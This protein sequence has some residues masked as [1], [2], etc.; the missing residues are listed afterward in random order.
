LVYNLKDMGIRFGST[1]IRNVVMEPSNIA[2]TLRPRPWIRNPRWLDMPTI[3][4]NESRF[5]AL[6]GISSEFKNQFVF[7]VNTTSGDYTVDWGDG[8]TDTYA[9]NAVAE[10]TY[11]YS[12]LN[13]NTE[14]THTKDGRT[15]RQALISVTPQAG[16][17]FDR[18]DLIEDPPNNSHPYSNPRM[19]L[20]MVFGS[21]NITH[22]SSISSIAGNYCKDLEHI[23]IVSFSD[24]LTSFHTTFGYMPCLKSI[25][26]DR[27]TSNI[28][29]W[30]NAFYECYSIEQIP[31]LDFSGATTFQNTF[32]RCMKLVEA[33]S[34]LSNA[35]PTRVDTMFYDCVLLRKIPM[36]DT[37]NCTNFK[38]MFMYCRNLDFA[39]PL[40]TSNGTDFYRMFFGCRSLKEI[41]KNLDTSSTNQTD[42]N[43]NYQM[44]YDCN[45]IQTIPKLTNLAGSLQSMFQQCFNLKR[46]PAIDFSKA[47]NT[48][49]MFYNCNSLQSL[50]A[51]NITGS[52]TTFGMFGYCYSLKSIDSLATN[53]STDFNGMFESCFNLTKLPDDFT[54]IS[55]SNPD[56]FERYLGNTYCL[57]EITEG[58][59]SGFGNTGVTDYDE[60][61]E[62]TFFRKL[63]NSFTGINNNASNITKMTQLFNQARGV[64]HV[65]TIDASNVSVSMPNVFAN[66]YCLESGAILSGVTQN[67]SYL[68]TNLDRE[69]MV[70]IFSGLGNASQTIN[71]NQTP[72]EG[73]LTDED[74]AIATNKGWTI[75]T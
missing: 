13:A 71:I 49:Y 59:C 48:Q 52:T 27:S 46:I 18:V 50:P 32:Y 45:Q 40:D 65:P 61:F 34:S 73:N 60:T 63:P 11:N 41:P 62:S 16:Q 29:N 31:E 17:G 64:K 58:A 25:E 28:T 26:I 66:A 37:S 68:S 55:A 21:P 75:A 51:L 30:T 36:M 33:P 72:A 57:Y 42:S 38:N 54:T 44:F 19:Y 14:F 9:D 67:I 4:S 6:V 1:P 10:H 43:P 56:A 35:S 47:T 23:R 2:R 69:A 20:D 53:S 24:S 5:T 70:A 3:A 22:L 7:K 8:N 12:D 39:P 15:Y 74:R